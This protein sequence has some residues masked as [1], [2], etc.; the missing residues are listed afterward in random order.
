MNPDYVLDN[1]LRTELIDLLCSLPPLTTYAGRD[2]WLLSLPPDICD[3]VPRRYEHCKIDLASIIDAFQS[4]Q[5]ADGRSSILVLIDALLPEIEDLASG[6][7][8]KTLRQQIEDS[9]AGTPF[10]THLENPFLY[11]TPIRDQRF[12]FGRTAETSKALS[13]VAGKQPVSIVGPRRIGKSSFLFHL[14][15]PQVKAAHGLRDDCVFVY[16]DCQVL[17]QDL[18]KS[19]VYHMLLEEVVEATQG[20]Y[21]PE[22]DSRKPMTYLDFERDLDQI[23]T[24]GPQIVFL[25][26]EFEQ[27][28]DNHQLG[29]DF[30]NELRGLGQTGKVI[31]VTASGQTLYELSFQDTNILSSPFFNTFFTV[32]LGLLK[33]QEAR[34]LVDGLAAMADFE[35]FDENDYVFLQ[36]MAGPHPFYLQMA[37]S[38]LFEEKVE[39]TGSTAPDYDR[40]EYRYAQE[41][42][43]NFQYIWDN[44]SAD[45]RRALRLLNEGRLDEVTKEEMEQLDQKCLVYQ[46]QIFSSAFIEFAER[47][48]VQPTKQPV[49][50]AKEADIATVAV[51]R[52]DEIWNHL[53]RQALQ[54]QSLAVIGRDSEFKHKLLREL[55]MPLEASAC[56]LFGREKSF[57]LARVDKRLTEEDV[58]K[59]ISSHVFGVKNA[60]DALGSR[61][62][63]SQKALL[64]GYEGDFD[65]D[66][67]LDFVG[68]QPQA[69]LDT[70][71]IISDRFDEVYEVSYLPELF[72]PG[73]ISLVPVS[74]EQLLDLIIS[75]ICGSVESASNKRAI[76]VFD[77]SNSAQFPIGTLERFSCATFWLL[78]ASYD[79][80]RDCV[81]QIKNFIVLKDFVQPTLDALEAD[82]GILGVT[83]ERLNPSCF[84]ALGDFSYQEKLRICLEEDV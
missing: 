46:R 47:N 12:F 4:Q 68:R 63:D 71:L 24:P 28:V 6:R 39:R 2:T 32:Q 7:R 34:A 73:T 18:T 31:Y 62:I 52:L 20:K 56:F 21:N 9:L 78:P 17:S 13:L 67:I 8:L 10:R 26:D 53:G 36:R 76:F 75:R 48:A 37:C 33:L 42:Q 79:T 83:V 16:I 27:I 23:I 19:D 54:S 50:A 60:L 61:L 57:G 51:R 49:Q 66:A 55:V 81:T 38:L 64:N 41:V 65:K 80:I 29:Q 40:V 15:D 84:V 14:S 44:L 43:D 11:R 69:T 5:L 25:L 3:L 22:L 58:H 77:D 72:V 74:G 45:E 35:G 82:L 30:F 1:Q 70:L 59:I